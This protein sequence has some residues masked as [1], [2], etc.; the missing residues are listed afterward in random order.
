MLSHVYIGINDF[1][2]AF[3]F[4]SGVMEELGLLLKFSEPDK[5]RAGW[6]QA[7]VARPLFLIGR[8]YSGE[9]S[10][11]GNGQMVALLATDRLTVGRCYKRAIASGGTDEG[12]RGLMP[13]YHPNYYGAYFRDPDRNKLCICCH[14]LATTSAQ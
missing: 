7:G 3:A 10:S 4:Y 6:M 5:S 8:S 2:R 9:V 12:G 14:D 1:Q 11:P 13:L